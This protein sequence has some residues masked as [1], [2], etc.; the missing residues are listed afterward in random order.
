MSS[1]KYTG[2]I[3][4]NST[5]TLEAI[6][7]VTGYTNS[8]IAGPTTYTISTTPGTLIIYL[9]QPGAQSTTVAGAVTETFDALSTGTYTSP[10]VSIAGIGTYTGS[11]SDPFAILATDEYGGAIDSGS[12]T[13]TNYFA[14]GNATNS[15]NPAYLTFTQPVSY[16]GFWWSAGD[17]YNRVA[18]YSGST[19]CGSFSTAD[20]LRFLNGGSG[21]ITANNGTDYQTSAYFGNP[22][23]TS[24]NNDSTEP[25]AYV[26][27]S[28]TGVTITRV[29]FYNTSTSSAFESDNHSVIFLGQ[30]CDNSRD[31]RTRGNT[32]ARIA[33]CGA[34][35]HPR[36][37]DTAEP[38]DFQH[39]PWGIDQL[40][41]ERNGADFNNR[42]SLRHSLH[43]TG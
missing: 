19:L 8:A 37:R 9:S 42:D 43:S 12:S 39:N 2:A 15:S 31:I 14:V 40:H 35:I 36:R 6:A 20:L 25:F 18:L 41:D 24:S 13:P 22:N 32:H 29:A 21:T 33:S 7:V 5:E 11:S 1:T 23:I 28:I 16:L 34:R 30:H 10:Y 4:V 3:T 27:F 38:G 26:S 17:Q